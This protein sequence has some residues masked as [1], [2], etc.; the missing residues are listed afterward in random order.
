[1]RES[2]QAQPGRNDPC[3]CGAN[4]KYKQCCERVVDE[5]RCGP[6][7]YEGL[8][9]K[10]IILEEI[11]T[12]KEIFVQK[13]TYDDLEI[14]KDI[15]DSDVLLFVER[16]RNL[17]GSKPDL[18]RYMPAKTD[19][20]F[21]A[22]YF[23]SPDILSTVNLLTRYSLYC[24][25]IIVI[26][27]LSMFHGMSKTFAHSPFQEPQSWVRQ[28][29]RD[30]VYMSSMEE[31]IQSDL[32]FATAFPLMFHD[33]LKKQHTE[34]MKA[35]FGKMSPERW[36][37][38]VHETIEKQFYSGFTPAELASMQPK[39]TDV[40]MMRKLVD[41]DKWWERVSRYMPDVTRGKVVDT[42]KTMTR[43]T[44][45][46]QATIT[47]LQQEPRRYEW[48]LHREFE[49]RMNIFGSGMNLLDAEWFAEI[50]GSHLVTDSRAVWDEILAGEPE[51]TEAKEQR[52][53]LERSMSALA[54]A[55][56]KL[57]FHFLNDV[58]LDFA[59]QMRKEDRLVGF[60]TYLREFWNKIRRED[61]TEDERVSTIQEFQDNLSTQY[62][63]FKTE[64]EE[65]RRIV[66]GRIAVAGLSGAGAILSGQ[67]GLW[68][69]A[70]GAL[71]SALPDEAKRQTKHTEA[72]SVFLDLER[73]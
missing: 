14:S 37:R 42:L 23:G 11:R 4:R 64:F 3:S 68:L 51:K 56:Q 57:E 33:P 20:G 38:I 61:Q 26:D 9:I 73:R 16:V 63:R 22:L 35:R 19:P 45:E 24:D 49:S 32:I 62:E 6:R 39:Q 52:N 15:T 70:L 41:D 40:E 21:R 17:W 34:E 69:F 10:N 67:L 65:I 7:H 60:R 54:E 25:Q 58:P 2:R 50:T 59:L 71:A 43:H 66:V 12:F 36:D 5:V 30:G 27:P 8:S 72:L 29:V 1:M 48:A 13:L 53:K 46:L 44:D 47:R 28:I 18:L 31:W 55:F